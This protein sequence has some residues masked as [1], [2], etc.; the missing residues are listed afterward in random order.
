V[1]LSGAELVCSVEVA[2][3][4]ETV[5]FVLASPF[6]LAVFLLG[7]FALGIGMIFSKNQGDVE[8]CTLIGSA[9][10][11]A[12]STDGTTTI[13]FF[14]SSKRKKRFKAEKAFQKKSFQ[15]KRFK[16]KGAS[17]TKASLFSAL[18]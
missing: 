13:F 8:C 1:L 15:V 12:T 4:F 3:F 2:F 18:V 17:K 5:P 16:R 11:T 7:L 14:H 9:K 6:A 10:I